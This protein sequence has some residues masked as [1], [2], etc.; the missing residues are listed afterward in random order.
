MVVGLGIDRRIR[1]RFLGELQG[2]V[3]KTLEERNRLSGTIEP[4]KV[5]Q[6]RLFEFWDMLLPP[7]NSHS[8]DDTSL[9]PKRIL[10]VSHGGAIRALIQ[11]LLTMRSSH[12]TLDPS[13]DLS[14]R[15]GNCS[16]TEIEVEFD[17]GWKGVVRKYGDESCFTEV[18]SSRVPS[19]SVN[20]DI[21][22]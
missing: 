16:I 19:P 1:E 4:T 3:V 13:Q 8:D 17:G 10:L 5:I 6:A 14:G 15:L 20:V 18:G 7:S 22:E 11:G 2:K 21:V 12:Y 9:P